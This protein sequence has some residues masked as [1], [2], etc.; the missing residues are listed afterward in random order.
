MTIFDKRYDK[1]EDAHTKSLLNWMTSQQID[2]KNPTFNEILDNEWW[3]G[4]TGRVSDQNL[5][6]SWIG[7][8]EVYACTVE[9]TDT[10]F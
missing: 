1:E 8:W 2:T 5:Q 6:S 4:S 10:L 7:S 9:N 3:L